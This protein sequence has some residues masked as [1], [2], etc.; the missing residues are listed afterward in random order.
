[1]GVLSEVG[2]SGPEPIVVSGAW[3]S[4][5]KL[6]LA[7]DWS[8]LPAISV[9]RTWKVCAPS[10]SATV[11]C[12]EVQSENAAL[13]SRHSKVAPVSL[14]S[15]ANVGVLSPVVPS[16]PLSI[17]VSGAWV[18]IVNVRVAGDG[19]MFPAESLARA[20]NVWSPSA[21][22]TVVCG[23]VQAA[24]AAA[25]TR[26]SNVEPGSFAENVKVGVLSA[27]L[28]CGPVLIVVSG[29]AVSIVRS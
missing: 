18:S 22:A 5:V 9:A 8:R 23:E 6:R 4:I 12:G 7:A 19:S 3:V 16:G 14:E 2:L 29:A 26:H 15:K 25:S 21:S 17:V 24:K 20:A 11:V 10:A 1:M 27:T 13:S 28:P